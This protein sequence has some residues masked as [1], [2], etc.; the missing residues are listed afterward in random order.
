MAIVNKM[1]LGRELFKT[2]AQINAMIDRVEKDADEMG[3]NPID[4]KDNKGNW[5]LVPLLSAKAQCLHA[6]ALINQRD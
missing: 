5:V 1:E 2:T 6:L 3:I 4:L